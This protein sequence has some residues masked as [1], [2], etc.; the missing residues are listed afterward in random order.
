MRPRWT[1][2]NT[3]IVDYEVSRTLQA[4]S[5]YVAVVQH[6]VAT[7]VLRGENAGKTLHHENVVRSLAVVPLAKGRGSVDVRIP[8]SAA[9]MGVELIG[10]VQA[11][12]TLV[13]GIP[14]LGAA[15]SP[16]PDP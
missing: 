14:V 1:A 4:A 11:V 3:A 13:E 5:L 12:P 16:L 10:W 15:R 7:S 2:T 8:T 6:R 9:S